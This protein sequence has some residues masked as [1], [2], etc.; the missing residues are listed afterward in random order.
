MQMIDLMK[1]QVYHSNIVHSMSSDPEHKQHPLLTE[2][3]TSRVAHDSGVHQR[4]P[5]GSLLE[6]LS[7]LQKQM[8]SNQTQT[9]NSLTDTM[10]EVG[11]SELAYLVGHLCHEGGRSL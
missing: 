10:K 9:L 7:L 3:E 2:L 8:E 11:Y 1:E 5:G 6:H 4:E